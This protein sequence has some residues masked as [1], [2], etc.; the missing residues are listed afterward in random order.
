LTTPE[1][2][3]PSTVTECS[4]GLKE[5]AKKHIGINFTVQQKNGW[6]YWT[7]VK[8]EY[9][10][11]EQLQGLWEWYKKTECTRATLRDMSQDPS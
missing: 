8:T 1:I 7:Q 4:H 2:S 3:P 11:D 6:K 10:T 9:V 5:Y